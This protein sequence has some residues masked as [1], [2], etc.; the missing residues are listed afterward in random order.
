MSIL[1]Q[2]PGGWKLYML[3]LSSITSRYDGDTTP[4]SIVVIV[5]QSLVIVSPLELSNIKKNLSGLG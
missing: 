1:V 5:M 2:V 3:P 4:G